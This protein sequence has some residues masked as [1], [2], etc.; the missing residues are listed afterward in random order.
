MQDIEKKLE[1]LKENYNQES[2]KDFDKKSF[3]YML[4]CEIKETINLVENTLNFFKNSDNSKNQD[5]LI[6]LVHTLLDKSLN[7]LTY[8]PS[9]NHSF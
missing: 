1:F 9:K 5:E 6:T 3:E 2:K 4:H 8:H 7:S